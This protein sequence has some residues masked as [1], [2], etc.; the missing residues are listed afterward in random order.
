MIKIENK[1]KIFL[2]LPKSDKAGVRKHKVREFVYIGLV[3]D[4][5]NPL[6]YLLLK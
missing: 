5:M 1:K 3:S 2:F 4:Q 6:G